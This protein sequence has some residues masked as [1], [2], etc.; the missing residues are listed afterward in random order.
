MSRHEDEDDDQNGEH[1]E[2]SSHGFKSRIDKL[3]E[4]TTAVEL[5]PNIAEKCTTSEIWLFEQ[6]AILI[7]VKKEWIVPHMIRANRI[8]R[9]QD[10]YIQRLENRMERLESWKRVLMV[11]WGIIITVGGG[12][13]LAAI[14]E[15]SKFLVAR[16]LH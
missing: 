9:A 3:N 14:E 6:M 1:A 2:D 10:I 5:P 15:I 4:P 13:T 12:I 11:K 16:L 8:L 7:Q